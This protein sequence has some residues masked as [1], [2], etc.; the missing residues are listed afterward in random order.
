MLYSDTLHKKSLKN[1]IFNL[2]GDIEIVASIFIRSIKRIRIHIII[3][4]QLPFLYCHLYFMS[5][6]LIDFEGWRRKI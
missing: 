2:R 6:D 5:Y 3:V 4:I 1:L